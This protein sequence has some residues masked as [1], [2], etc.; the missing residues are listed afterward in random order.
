MK[1]PGF[2][3]DVVVLPGQRFALIRFDTNDAGSVPLAYCDIAPVTPNG[4]DV[5]VTMDALG[6]FYLQQH[7]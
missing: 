6:W 1:L 5:T 4:G 3:S 2:W 7:A